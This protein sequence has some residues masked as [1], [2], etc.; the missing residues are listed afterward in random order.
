M[1]WIF[2][3]S[4][5]HNALYILEYIFFITI[6]CIVFHFIYDDVIIVRKEPWFTGEHMFMVGIKPTTFL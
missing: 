4:M 5:H 1:H 3:E 6:Y 2:M